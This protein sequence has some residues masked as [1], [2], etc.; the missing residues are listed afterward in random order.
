MITTKEGKSHGTA[1]NTEARATVFVANISILLMD[2]ASKNILTIVETLP[3]NKCLYP[4]AL[5][6]FLK[7][8]MAE[9]NE[10][11]AKDAFNNDPTNPNPIEAI[12]TPFNAAK[13]ELAS[14]IP[15]NI[16]QI[17]ET[18]F[19]EYFSWLTRFCVNLTTEVLDVGEGAKTV[20]AAWSI[21]SHR[22]VV[23]GVVDI[24]GGLSKQVV[25]A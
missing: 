4:W 17:R 16:I 24:G 8:A 25:S 18:I 2:V 23:G 6:P 1:V 19:L 10:E 7:A 3:H 5:L 21:L 13:V 12:I 11:Y 20:R 14:W 15:E 22:V 9:L